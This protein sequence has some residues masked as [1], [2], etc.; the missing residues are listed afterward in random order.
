MLLL[1]DFDLAGRK[2]TVGGGAKYVSRRLGETG[3][4]F[5]LP[6]YTL[7]RLQA[8][9]EATRS[10]RVTA[11]V[12]NLTDKQYYPASFAALWVA[13]GEPRQFQVRATYKF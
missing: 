4:N 9:Y 3:T 6:G 1:K 13:P 7:L 5:Y 8:S 12:T 2:F 10:L 11:E